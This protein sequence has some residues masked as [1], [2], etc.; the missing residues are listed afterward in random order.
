MRDALVPCGIRARSSVVLVNI[1]SQI[2][3]D[4]CCR[5]LLLLLGV[6]KCVK[7]RSFYFFFR[8][9]TTNGW[10]LFCCIWFG[11]TRM[12]GAPSVGHSLAVYV[13][14]RLIIMLA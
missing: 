12:L 11:A 8:G 5:L 10:A 13:D 4:S 14:N 6:G 9:V 2:Y 1:Y 3:L 7:R